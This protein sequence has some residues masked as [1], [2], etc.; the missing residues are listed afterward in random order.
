MNISDMIRLNELVL[1]LKSNDKVPED[2]K[3]ILETLIT[4]LDMFIQNVILELR[5]EPTIFIVDPATNLEDV[6]GAKEGDVAIFK[7]RDGVVDVKRFD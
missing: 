2:V 3:I 4:R 1:L 6:E 7:N 5:A